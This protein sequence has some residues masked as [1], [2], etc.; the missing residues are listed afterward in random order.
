M[1]YHGY[2]KDGTVIVEGLPAIPDG[3][4]VT[5]VVTPQESGSDK[6]SLEQLAK[7]RA[8]L[9]EIRALPNENP[10]DTFSGADH[11]E[12]LY[13]PAQGSPNP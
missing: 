8:A 2:I 6:M 5:V 12:V 11:D 3:T 9:D 10:G 4:Q 1:T 13:G 7:Y